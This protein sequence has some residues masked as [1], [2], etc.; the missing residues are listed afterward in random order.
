MKR[1]PGRRAR[2]TARPSALLAEKDLFQQGFV[3]NEPYSYENLIAAG[4]SRWSSLLVHDTGFEI[5]QSALSVKPETITE[6]ADC[7]KAIVPMFQQSLVDYINEPGGRRT[8]SSP[9][10]S[11]SMDQFWQ[12]SDE[13]N[14]DAVQA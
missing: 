1:G 10:S 11:P 4:R 14:A 6:K 13:L 9:R 7:L 3:T 8:P 12:I 2:T 5:Y